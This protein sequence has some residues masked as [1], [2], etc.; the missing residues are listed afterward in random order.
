[1]PRR[2]SPQWADQL[3]FG[4]DDFIHTGLDHIDTDAAGDDVADHPTD[5]T[6]FASMAL[7]GADG[8]YFGFTRDGFLRDGHITNDTEAGQ[9]SEIQEVDM[10]FG[11]GFSADEVNAVAI[12]PL[13]HIIFVGLW[14]QSD[15][16]TGILEVQYNPSTGAL[17]SPYN[18][19][20]GAVTDFT[21][22]LFNDDNT[23]KVKAARR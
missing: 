1:M 2:R 7:D 23:G 13:N 17:T 3:W 8:L 21:H 18:A 16:Y 14:G 6:V 19:S 10:V 11:T 9:A 22:M 12:D 5:G 15:Q 20:T 4:V